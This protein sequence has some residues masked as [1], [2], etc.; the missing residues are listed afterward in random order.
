MSSDADYAAFLDKANQD[1]GSAET[2]DASQ[3]KSYGTKSVN[4]A[5]PKALEQVEEYYVSDSDEPFEP[6]ALEFDGDSVSAD[7]L[8]KLIGSDSVEEV[9]GTGFESQYKKIIDAVKAA[10]NGTVN[11]YRVELSGTRAE[12]YVVGVDKAEGRIVGLKA[13]A[14]ES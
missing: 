7:D 14:V 5:V 2:K 3:K 6:V 11:V 1:T 8:K 9:K 12:Y 13:L 4:T 10:G